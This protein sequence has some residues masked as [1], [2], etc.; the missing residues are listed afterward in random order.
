LIKAR[1]QKPRNRVTNNCP[2]LDYNPMWLNECV[3]RSKLGHLSGVNNILN[4]FDKIHSELD[5]NGIILAGPDGEGLPMINEF[6]VS[7]NGSGESRGCCES[8]TFPQE[9]IFAYREPRKKNGKY[10]HCAKTKTE[11]LPYTSAV[12][13][14]LIIVKKHLADQVIVNS[15]KPY[16]AWDR[17]SEWCQRILGYGGRFLPDKDDT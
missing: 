3:F 12:R 4:D 16:S 13:A 2:L 1:N 14:F 5:R 6:G 10:F 15:D 8:F 11:G 17:P 9:L 7:F